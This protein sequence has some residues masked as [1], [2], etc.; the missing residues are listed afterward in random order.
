MKDKKGDNSVNQK[1]VE[2]HK[3]VKIQKN[4]NTNS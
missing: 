1:A 2:K 3:K 4:R